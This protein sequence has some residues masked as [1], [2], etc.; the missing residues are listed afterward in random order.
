MPR[1]QRCWCRQRQPSPGRPDRYHALVPGSEL[2]PRLAGRVLPVDARGRVL[3]LR[4]FDPADPG[5]PFWFTVGGAP[6]HGETLAEAAAREL[7]E[8]AGIVADAASLGD[9]VWHRATEFSFDGTRF[10]QEE[11]YF[12]LRVGS[13]AVSLDGM[14]YIEKETVLGYRWLDP[15]E[16]ESLDEPL[17]P[18]ELPRLLRDL[19][20]R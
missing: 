2:V 12:L 7:R 13:P 9:P 1:P 8:E 14:D 3:L 16:L 11:E 5:H 19:T 15:A 20:S 6:D 17:F 18:P 4:G 10:Q